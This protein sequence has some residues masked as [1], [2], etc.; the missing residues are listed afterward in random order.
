MATAYLLCGQDYG[1][2]FEDYEQM[3]QEL[4]N[5]IAR[6]ST[7]L[8]DNDSTSLC[9]YH[10]EYNT[11]HDEDLFYLFGDE[12]VK[13]DWGCNSDKPIGLWSMTE[14]EDEGGIHTEFR[15]DKFTISF[16]LAN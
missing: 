6:G 7:D 15:K 8:S 2:L 5:M 13:V 16:A 14:D 12:K 1:Y 10:I 11:R 4:M 9:V 3:C